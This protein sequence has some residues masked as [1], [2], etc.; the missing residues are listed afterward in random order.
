[1]CH[2]NI[3]MLVHFVVFK[4]IVRIKNSLVGS[5]PAYSRHIFIIIIYIA[6]LVIL[7]NY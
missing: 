6:K 7:A 4:T 5:I 2:G 3:K 1:M